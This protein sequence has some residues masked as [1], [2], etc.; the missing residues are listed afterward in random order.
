MMTVSSGTH[1]QSVPSIDWFAN[2]EVTSIYAYNY[3]S[4]A[5]C[6]AVIEVNW[7]S[8]SIKVTEGEGVK[9]RLNGTAFGLYANPVAI[10][11]ICSGT[12]AN[13]ASDPDPGNYR[14]HFKQ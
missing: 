13:A 7:T 1:A 2:N 14:L 8:Q 10:G 6:A 12:V 5:L 9:V 3:A 4:H 11:V